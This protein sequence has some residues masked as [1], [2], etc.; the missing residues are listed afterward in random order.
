MAAPAFARA[1]RAASGVL[2]PL[3]I[4]ASSAYQ[5]GVKN[6]CLSSA[7]STRH[8]SFLQM[9]VVSSAPS[10]APSVR[11]LT[12]GHAAAVL[13]RLVIR[14]NYGKRRLQEKDA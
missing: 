1:V 2:R 14:K 8:F 6:A 11:N 5:N 4:L 3:N 13:N 10:L 12:C 7:V 9:P